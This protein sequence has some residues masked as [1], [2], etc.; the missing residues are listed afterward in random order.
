MPAAGGRSKDSAPS[1]GERT[2]YGVGLGWIVGG[3]PS[4]EGVGATPFFAGIGVGLVA[5]FGLWAVSRRCDCASRGGWRSRSGYDF[6]AV[7]SAAFFSLLS[8]AS[9]SGI[10]TRP[11]PHS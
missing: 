8:A 11:T 3:F 10:E 1:R 9:G 2:T 7:D 4:P 6:A 5:E